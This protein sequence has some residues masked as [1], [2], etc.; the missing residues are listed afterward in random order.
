MLAEHTTESKELRRAP[1]NQ[2]Q[3]V[4][5]L[6]DNKKRLKK[7]SLSRK[8]VKPNGALRRKPEGITV[9]KRVSIG[10]EEKQKTLPHSAN[11]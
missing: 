3:E 11:I 2:R 9:K 4:C 7:Y 6:I 8:I 1:K 5:R 10:L